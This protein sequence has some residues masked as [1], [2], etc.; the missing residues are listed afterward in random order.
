[1]VSDST[2]IVKDLPQLNALDLLKEIGWFG[3]VLEAR[4]QL[5]FDKECEWQDIHEI[6]APEHA[7]S[8]SVYAEFLQF[9]K[10]SPYERLLLLLALLPH[11]YPQALDPFFSRNP[12]TERGYTEFGGLRGT[13]HSG[14]L[15]TGDTALLVLRAND[16]ASHLHGH[17]LF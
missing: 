2:A 15:P 10:L 4:M 17:Q 13:A 7:F 14:F 9:Y 12:H 6:P 16:P 8:K 11:I 5:Y 1:M 3:K